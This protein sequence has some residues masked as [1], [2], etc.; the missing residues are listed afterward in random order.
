MPQVSSIKLT[1]MEVITNTL[2]FPSHTSQPLPDQGTFS[3]PCKLFHSLQLQALATL[4]GMYDEWV[5]NMYNFDDYLVSHDQLASPVSRTNHSTTH[6][7]GHTNKRARQ[8]GPSWLK[9]PRKSRLLDFPG[10]NV[11]D[12]HGNSCRRPF[13]FQC[14]EEHWR[15]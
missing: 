1:P 12:G 9:V 3:S 4:T 6:T 14:F 7:L 10:R 2:N 15:G 8:Y 11:G 13:R 5:K